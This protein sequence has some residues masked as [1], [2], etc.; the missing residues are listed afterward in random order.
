MK[1]GKRMGLLFSTTAL[2]ITCL[3]MVFT[4][5]AWY[6]V[7]KQANVTAG[8][9]V[10]A[11]NESIRILDEVKAVK[12]SLNGDIT[13][14]TYNRN[15]SGRLV[16]AKS[17][18]YTASTDTTETITEFAEVEYFVIREMLPGE[19]VDITIGYTIDESKDGSNYTIYLKN[20]VGDAFIIDEKTHYVTGAFRYKNISL[21]D[22]NN[23][24]AV[25]FTPDSD[26]TWFNEYSI[27]QNDSETLD[28]TILHHTWDSDYGSLYYTFS[29]YE[30]FTQYYRLI[31]QSE[32]SYGNLL[33]RKN[34][35]I[36]EIFVI[37]G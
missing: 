1:N 16:L 28:K 13:T 20:I 26:Y 21:K 10:T 6:A 18:I 34:F 25:G 8:T 37:L 27:S 32:N 23:A 29:I 2:F 4:L 9:G 33:S 11:A 31:A 17:V 3:L 19:H 36:G 22:S 12:Y 5:F 7:N 15:S 14:N 35:N 24:D 30:D